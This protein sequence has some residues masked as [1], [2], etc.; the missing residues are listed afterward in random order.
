MSTQQL[1][2]NKIGNFVGLKI[3]EVL[4]LLSRKADREEVEALPRFREAAN[5]SEMLYLSGVR[6]GDFCLVADTRSGFRLRALPASNA[7][8][9]DQVFASAGASVVKSVPF[10][11]AV[12]PVIVHDMGRIP[13]TITVLDASGRVNVVDWKPLDLNR[14]QLFFTEMVGGTCSLTFAG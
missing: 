4:D 14:I 12:S 9:W 3:R 5:R 10:Q 1:T 13:T 7:E 6:V 11:D 2:L 8:N